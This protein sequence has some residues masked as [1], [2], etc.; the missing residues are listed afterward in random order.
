MGAEGKL[1][2]NLLT[3]T[4]GPHNDDGVFIDPSAQAKDAAIPAVI[5]VPACAVAHPDSQ[6]TAPMT[7]V[8]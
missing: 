1:V 3:S 2:E 6:S 8:R 5:E 7:S 4:I